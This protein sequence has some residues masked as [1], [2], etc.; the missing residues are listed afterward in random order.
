MKIKIFQE[1]Q[2][3]KLTERMKLLTDHAQYYTELKS[4]DNIGYKKQNQLVCWGDKELKKVPLKQKE[5]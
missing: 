5:Y 3:K 2:R 1:K 4:L